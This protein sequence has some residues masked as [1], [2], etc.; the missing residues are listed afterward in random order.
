MSTYQYN[1]EALKNL[2]IEDTS[3][4]DRL[5]DSESAREAHLKKDHAKVDKRMTL[6]EAI[7]NYVADG[8][9]MTDSGF[10]YVRTPHQAFWEIMRQ[11]KKNLQCI[12]APN[13]N[14]SFLIF[15]NNCD[16]SHNS[17]VGVEMRGIDRNY[18]R[19]LRQG[20]VKILS[21][22]S[23]GAVAL[24]LKAAQLGAPGVFSKQMLGSDM[25]KYNPYTKVMQNPM[26]DDPDPVVF[27]PA[28]FPD[29]TIIHCQVA[30]KY[31]NGYIYGPSVND[32]A[33]AA[34]ARKLI[35]TAE[36]IV[37]ESEIRTR[38]GTIIPFFYADAVVE[39]PF[40][41]VPGNMPG[42]YYWS[43]QW[44]EKLIRFGCAS[45][46]NLK[47]FFDEWVHGVKDQFEFVDK[48]GGAKWIAEARIQTKAAEGDHED[49]DFSYDEFTKT[50]DPGRYY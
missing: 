15:N 13:T 2:Q 47:V 16:Y 49:I 26:R 39:L 38:Q 3:V 21:E 30:D 43:R 7:A 27:I 22:W 11:G 1:Q 40:G 28:L 18:D 10:A 45:D 8:D 41:A 42:Y 31:G 6:T 24:G 19:M 37:P 9:C 48:L 35:I 23:H 34:A 44:W 17:Y 14:H 4:L 25:L 36:E 5:V 33:T 46:E 12:A 50:H 32:V 20:R 29:V